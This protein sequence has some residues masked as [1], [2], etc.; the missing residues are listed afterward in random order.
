[1]DSKIYKYIRFDKT[2]A[3]KNARIFLPDTNELIFCI[4][5]IVSYMYI[6]PDLCYMIQAV[7]Y[8]VFR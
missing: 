8:G 3:K 2:L 6:V 7:L 5:I 1:V 4:W